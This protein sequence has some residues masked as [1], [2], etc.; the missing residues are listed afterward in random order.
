MIST[1]SDQKNVL[2]FQ[3]HRLLSDHN[4]MECLQITKEKGVPKYV[5][6][7]LN[8]SE[9]NKNFPKLPKE[10]KEVLLGFSKEKIVLMKEDV[11][12][13]FTLQRAGVSYEVYSRSA[14]SRRLHEHMERMKPFAALVKWYHKIPGEKGSFKTAPGSFSTFKPK[15]EFEVV[16]NGTALQVNT[17]IS[18]NGTPYALGEFNRW[19]FLLLSGNEYFILSY[20]DYQTLE[21]LKENDPQQ[22]SHQPNELGEN[23]LAK[24]EADYPVNRNNLFRKNELRITPVNRVMLSEI[25]Q[26]FLVLTPQWE[27]D[28]F[29]IE[30]PWKETYDITRN[31]QSYAIYRNQQ[32]EKDLWSL[33]EGLHP[34]F[35]KQ[36]NGYYYLSFE[37]AQKKQWFLKVYHKLLELNIQVIG[38]DMLQHFRYSQHKVKAAVTIKKEVTDAL[39]LQM[40]ISFGEEEVSLTEVQKIVQAGQR[41]ILLQDG[42]LGI[43]NDEWLQT[44]GTIIRH[45]KI[46]GQEIQVPRWLAFSE[47]ETADGASVL[48]PTLH[49]SWLEKWQLWQKEGETVYEVP[50]VINAKLRPYQQKGFEWM[51]LLAEA[52]A[53]AC[54]ADDMGLGKTLQTISVLTHQLHEKAN[55]RHLIVC[56]SSLIYNWSQELQ[57]FSPHVKVLIYHGGNRA[58]QDAATGDYQVIITS[59]GTVRQDIEEMCAINFGT[60]VLDESHNI[61]NPAAQI[62]KAVE[63][64]QSGFRVALSGTPVMNNTFDLYAQ[65]NFL[66][67]G[68]F[69]SREFFRREYADAIDQRRESDKIKTLQRITAP[70]VLRRT[71]EQVASDLPAKT[72]MVMWCEMSMA[73]K[74]LYDEIKDSI[75]QSVFLNI[76]QEGLNKSKLAVLKGML[77]LRQICNSPLLLPS[78]EQT[79]ND[80]VKTDL[81]MN[82]LQNNLKDHK[83]LVFSQFT[84]MLNLLAENCRE[85]G[86][87]YYHLDGSTPPE[88]RQ[89]LVNQ[90]QAPNNTTNVFL[91]SLKAGNAG[92]NLT[93]ASYVILFDPW[94]NT[95][96]QQQAIDRTHRIGQT[97][98]VF[99]Y[100]MICKDTIEEKIISLQQHKKQLAEELISEDEG[101]VKSLTEDDIKYLFS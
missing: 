80:S 93:A 94:W 99:A 91:I 8:S 10:V 96:V 82:E 31:G 56:P 88:K 92:L 76:E 86:I 6:S 48:K 12:K 97:K 75:R 4:L 36:L 49:N 51:L 42:S 70:F 1:K 41:A 98:N 18:I 84:S 89:E 65:L 5:N 16:K 25:S 20:K 50:A 3:P 61:K 33:L 87:A 7:E 30:G 21:W 60:V 81:L 29:I 57:K 62:T 19:Q 79:C 72:E 74:R 68:I 40:I 13:K 85:Q 59:Y 100:K 77:K 63:R 37:E 32:D 11:Q 2:L 44:Y 14:I 35:Q 27:Y 46:S 54:L 26:S 90:F 71:K 78:E 58:I 23:I 47:E 45:G 22:Y 67:P 24:L 83:V 52:G 43:L 101:F 95:A 39:V 66:L 55:Q 9:L 34:N 69:G 28:G 64:L 17:I 15:L 73:Q 38:M 53:G